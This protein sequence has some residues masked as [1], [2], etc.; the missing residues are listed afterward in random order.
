VVEVEVKAE[1][2]PPEAV[3]SSAIKFVEASERVN[4]IVEV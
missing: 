2:V 4:V 1:S 3:M